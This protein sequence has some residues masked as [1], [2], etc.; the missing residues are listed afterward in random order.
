MFASLSKF[1]VSPSHQTHIF[2][3][4]S[5]E[6]FPSDNARSPDELSNDQTTM[7]P[8]SKDV[9]S[10][11]ITPGTN[12]IENLPVASSSSHPTQEA[13][14]DPLWQQAMKEEL[15][16]LEKT[17]TWDLVD[18]PIDKTLV[19]CKW[20]YKITT[21]SDGSVERYKAHLVAKDFTQEY[22]IDYEETFAYVARL[23]TIRSLLVIVVIHKWK[24]FQRD[25]KMPFL[26]NPIHSSSA[27]MA[28][29]SKTLTQTDSS[30]RMAI[31][32]KFTRQHLPEF[33]GGTQ[34][35]VVEDV[36][37]QGWCFGYS[38]RREGHPKPVFQAGWLD[39]VRKNVSLGGTESHFG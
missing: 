21:H 28:L 13:S 34:N 31:P 15:Q 1:K 26:M 6:L 20:V 4:P 3:N 7:A 9:S 10:T 32:S 12:E 2:T 29:F 18:L 14:L 19:G 37:G 16:A 38:I 35:S 39:F 30:K 22:G 24:L 8:I 5:L 17:G 11:D 36:R 23:T 25:V 27:L 33:E